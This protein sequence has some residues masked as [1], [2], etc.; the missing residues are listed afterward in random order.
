MESEDD[1]DKDIPGFLPQDDDEKFHDL[2]P[3]KR[4][5]LYAIQFGEVKKD[6]TK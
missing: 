3:K 6:T 2:I 4:Q 1:S 5:A